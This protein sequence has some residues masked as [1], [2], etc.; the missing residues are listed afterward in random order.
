MTDLPPG[1]R[2]FGSP[3]SARAPLLRR[4]L[5]IAGGAAVA[6]LAGWGFLAGRAALAKEKEREAPVAAPSR[7]RAVTT[8]AGANVAVVLDSAT[9]QRAGIRTTVL[10][11]A[12]STPGRI[13]L[14]GALIADPGRVS[15][16]RAPVPGRVTTVGGAWPALGD[17]ISAGRAVAQV[18]DAQPLVVPRAGVVT[19]VSAQPGELVQSGQELLQITDFQALLARIVWPP[20]LTMAPPPTLT[21]ELLGASGARFAARY[22]A[23]AADVDTLTL[24]PVFLYRVSNP[25]A[26]ARP[27][28][29]LLATIDDAR[30]TT[31][32]VVIATSAVV[33]WEGLTWVYVQ[34]ITLTKPG[35]PG[36]RQYIRV[37][38]D[39][40]RPI[41]G[42]WFVPI[43]TG[44][45]GAR[46]TIVVRGAQQLLSEEFR[47]RIQVGD[48]S[49]GKR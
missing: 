21:V 26:T 13:Q 44:G 38:V 12:A 19:R 28:R 11:A 3:P 23:P 37:R 33:Q 15:V 47:A 24:A 43:V 18:S 27:G 22:V 30:T 34:H 48:A 4:L 17:T 29:P 2:G 39:P 5:L 46:D 35:T 32:G 7:L 49:G 1:G 40:T 16:V 31:R 10:G 6:G 42:G 45:V 20:A 41:D 25:G 8:P 9:A 14:P 36:E